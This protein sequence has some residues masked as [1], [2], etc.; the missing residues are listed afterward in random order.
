MLNK[1]N[2]KK[3]AEISLHLG[4]NFN[5]I[6]E[7]VFNIS[8]LTY[9]KTLVSDIYKIMEEF[10]ERM[11]SCFTIHCSQYQQ[12]VYKDEVNKVLSDLNIKG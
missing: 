1:E 9:D 8:L 6:L 7:D 2:E 5:E 3:V 11:R 10:E 12:A 4:K